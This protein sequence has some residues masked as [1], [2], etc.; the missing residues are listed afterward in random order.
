[1]VGYSGNLGRAHESE[2]ILAA[3]TQLRDESNFVFLLIGGGKQFDALAERVK[4]RQLEG[5]FRFVPYQKSKS[6]KFSLSVPDVH[7]LSLKPQLEGLIVPS[8]FYGIAAAGR[9]MIAI[10]AEDGEIG[11]LISQH[12]CGHVI[13]PGDADALVRSILDLSKNAPL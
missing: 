2:T 9:P 13:K 10:A 8:K 1:M 7:W 4:A 6:L 5:R 3:A 12:Q 11:W